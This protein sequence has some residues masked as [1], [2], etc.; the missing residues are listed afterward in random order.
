[1]EKEVKLSDVALEAG[2]STVTASKALTGKKVSASTLQKVVEAARKLGYQSRG[3]AGG[4]DSTGLTVGLLIPERF[5]ADSTF[6]WK[7]HR[8]LSEILSRK[9]LYSNLIVC[10]LEDE[11][12]LEIPAI[13]RDNPP[14]GVIALGELSADYIR[15]LQRRM[16]VPVVYLDYYLSGLG[17]DSVIS[18]GYLGMY[19]LTRYVISQGHR[20]IAFVGT[21]LA[22]SSITDRYHGFLRAMEESGLSVPPEWVISD[23]DRV[24]NSAAIYHIELPEKLP[25]AFVCNCDVTAVIIKNMLE[26]K[27]IRVPEDISVTGFDNYLNLD[28]AEL[29]TTCDVRMEDMAESATRLILQKIR[30]ES[31]SRGAHMISGELIIR[32][33]VASRK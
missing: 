11:K 25:T 2:V 12:G 22:T 33:S 1:M 27:A 29:L 14:D 9:G 16:S 13:L 19:E 8:T 31:Y 28:S 15:I 7:M 18:N 20:E 4:A 17:M 6:Y 21:P 26:E 30:K 32:N 10:S 3:S 24:V 5:W 23:R